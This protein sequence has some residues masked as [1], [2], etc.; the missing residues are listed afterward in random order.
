MTDKL[1][2]ILLLSGPVSSGKS[3]LANGLAKRCGMFI[4]KT[5][6]VIVARLGE[7]LRQDRKALQV[8]GERLDRNT[9]GKWVLE[10]LRENEDCLNSSRDVIVDSV[11]INPQIEA[12][13]EAYGQR[14]L[15]IHLTAP[16]DELEQRYNLRRRQGRE[17]PLDYSEVRENPTEKQVENLAKYAD[18]VIDTKRCTEQDVLVRTIS[19]LRT[20]EGRGTGYVDVVVGGQYGSEGKGQ[21][22]AYIAKEYDLLVRVGGPN[23]GHTVFEVPKPYP[24]HQLP[25]GTRKSE[26][27]LLIGPGAVLRVGRLLKEISECEVDAQRLR[28]DGNAMVITDDDIKAEADLVKNIGSTGQG[29]GAATARRIMQRN[30]KTLLAR[31]IPELKPFLGSSL[32]ILEDAFL[33][34]KRVLLEGTQ[35]TG[36]SLYHGTY[37][38]VT[39]R[40]TSAMGCLAEAGIPPDRVRRV[41]MVCRT[42]PI[43]V[44]SPEKETSGPLRDLNWEEIARRS[45]YAADTLR[46]AEKTTTT[47]RQRRIG[48]FEWVLLHRAALLNGATD[49]ALTFTDYISKKN[50][51]AKRF[52]QLTQDTINFIQEIERVAGAPVSLISTGFNSRS[53]IDRRSW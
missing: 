38:Y 15:H 36:L 52:E 37:P 27:Q 43:R 4:F 31:D 1:G 12:I 23:A 20:R 3:T 26:A 40:D 47:K 24:H 17:K 10:G 5:S 42:Y 32:D 25:S 50:V 39:S 34:N 9:R 7:R 13:R 11:R 30:K 51:D 44:E 28:I 2:R 46:A 41:M 53:I 48:E 14:V 29:V 45:G 19:H 22:V 8:E 21:I 49:V 35:G 18:I 33:G 16:F 6:E